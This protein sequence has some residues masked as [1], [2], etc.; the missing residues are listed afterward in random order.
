MP[1]V[2]RLEVSILCASAFPRP[3]YFDSCTIRWRFYDYHSAGFNATAE[4]GLSVMLLGMGEATRGCGNSPNAGGVAAPIYAPR[5][6]AG[7]RA[8]L[9]ERRSSATSFTV[10][11][12]FRIFILTR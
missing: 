7:T 12:T 5:Y 2:S 6:R 3:D 11:P 9:R 1:E 8:R 10:T 4:S